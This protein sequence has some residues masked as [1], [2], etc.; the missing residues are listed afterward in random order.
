MAQMKMNAKTATV[1]LGV[2][3]L[4]GSAQAGSTL[5]DNGP[6]VTNPGGG[7][8][9]A[10]A[11]LV[12][13]QLGMTSLGGNV[14]VGSFRRA[15]NFTVGAGGWRLDS[16]QVFGYFTGG[17]TTTSP[18]ENL[19]VRIWDANPGAGGTVV[20]GDMTTNILASSDWTG[21]YR[22]STNSPL[23]N[24][25][26]IWDA[27]GSLG[28]LVLAEGEYWVEVGMSSSLG[29]MWMPPVSIPDQ[30]STG[31]ALTYTVS[32]DSW[33]PW[34]DGG[35]G[36]PL[37]MPFVLTGSVVPAPGAMALLGLGGLAASRRRRG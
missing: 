13:S 28:G 2:L 30:S 20:A 12:Q 9:G 14:N 22:A 10:D 35:A 4:A 31:D 6:I 15:D 37:G 17:D 7:F 5:W 32:S 25:R 33:G 21:A 27:V 26:P 36:T 18:I 19:F 3:V 29:T 11:S 34:L 8:G 24:T 16:I 1:A 23:G